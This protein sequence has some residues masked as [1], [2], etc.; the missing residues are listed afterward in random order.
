MSTNPLFNKVTVGSARAVFIGEGVAV[1][2]SC[3]RGE[4][5]RAIQR[6]SI[7]IEAADDENVSVI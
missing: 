2:V 3:G 1:N 4:Y 7:L 6:I 5:F